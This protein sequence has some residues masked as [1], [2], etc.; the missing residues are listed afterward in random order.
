MLR[1]RFH[2]RGGQGM[3]TASRILGSAAFQAGFVIQDSPV[4]GAERGGAPMAA[5]ARIARGPIRE[6][7]VI[8]R[9]G[10]GLV[11]DDTLL[12]DPPAQPLAG[13]DPR[14]TGLIKSAQ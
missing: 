13:C 11:G 6:G 10:L 5:F 3:K 4:Y 9:P 7:G 2:G 1:I 8:A 12:A 14:G